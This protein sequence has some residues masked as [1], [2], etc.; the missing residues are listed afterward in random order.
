LIYIYILGT[1][2]WACVA[3]ELEDRGGLYLENCAIA[4]KKNVREE[5][6]ASFSGYLEYSIDKASADKLWELSEK[7]TNIR[8]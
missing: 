5:C 3:S 2:I 8:D 4:E 6:Y 7:L 1:T